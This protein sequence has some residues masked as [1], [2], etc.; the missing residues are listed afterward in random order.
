MKG[1]SER[2]PRKNLRLIAGRPLFHWITDTLLHSRAVNEVVVDTD[3]DEIEEAV[4][5]AFPAV[6][7]HRRPEHLHG[8]FIPMHDVVTEVARN[9]SHDHLLQTHSTNPLLR[10]ETV[11]AAIAAYLEPG[12]HDSLMS[13]TALQTRFFFA[14]GSPV[15]HD[16]AVLLRTQDLP[17]ILEENSCIYI[18]PREQVVETGRRVGSRPKLF[19]MPR[20]QAVDID[21]ELD[22]AIAAFLLEHQDG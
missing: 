13:V 1:H 5:A 15:N 12:D 10:P 16:P 9:L 19:P 20:E 8:D 4:R 21:E 7:I 17:P 2:V 18:A 14:D 22:F 3:S 6:T 11:D